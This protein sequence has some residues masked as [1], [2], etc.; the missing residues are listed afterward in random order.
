MI[1]A[2]SDAFGWTDKTTLNEKVDDIAEILCR[3]APA[4]HLKEMRSRCPTCR[5]KRVDCPECGG[6]RLL[7]MKR[8]TKSDRTSS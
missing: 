3:I 1:K 8:L 4:I 7:K 2:V 5:G 6:E